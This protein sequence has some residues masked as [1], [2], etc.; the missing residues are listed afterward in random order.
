MLSLSL[1]VGGVEK[2]NGTTSAPVEV[3]AKKYATNNSCCSIIK[4]IV[5]P[6]SAIFSLVLRDQICV[7]SLS[8]FPL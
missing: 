1:I 5:S 4:T 7:F 6:L 8:L 3:Q 2:K